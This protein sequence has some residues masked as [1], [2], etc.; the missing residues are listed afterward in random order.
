MPRTRLRLAA[1]VT[2]LVAGIVALLPVGAGGGHGTAI[3]TTASGATTLPAGNAQ[4]G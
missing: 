3:T 2:A 1:A 4:W